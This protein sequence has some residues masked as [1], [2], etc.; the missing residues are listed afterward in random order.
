[1]VFYCGPERLRA[2]V[3]PYNFKACGERS[4]VAY[5]F[6]PLLDR[7]CICLLVYVYLYFYIPTFTC[8]LLYMPTFVGILYVYFS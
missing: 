1:M 5:G 2:T 7:Y 3:T 8:L 6:A 4:M